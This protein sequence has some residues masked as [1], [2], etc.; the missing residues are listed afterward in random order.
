MPIP[1]EIPRILFRDLQ[2][3]ASAANVDERR[4][5]AVLSTEY[6]VN[7]GDYAEV[8]VHRSNAVDLSRA[9]LPLCEQHDRGEL[10]IG[11]IENIHLDGRTL[12]GEVVLGQSARAAE[13]WPDIERGIVRSLSVGY[14]VLAYQWAGETLQVT[15]WQPVE[16]SLVSVPADPGAG[17]YRS[18][19]M[20]TP[21]PTPNPANQVPAETVRAAE[22]ERIVEIRSI[23]E[24]FS[25]NIPTIS[26]FVDRAIADG[27]TIDRFRARLLD[28]L[29]SNDEAAGGHINRISSLI[30]PLGGGSRDFISAASDAIL[31]RSGARIENPHPATNDFR[32][33]SVL[34]LARSCVS[35][36]G[37]T[38]SGESGEV[39]IR[40]AMSTSD[41]PAIVGDTL[42]KSLR[43]GVESEQASHRN[44]CVVTQADDFRTQSRV[45]LGSAPDLKPVLELGEYENGPLE[46]DRNTLVPVKFGRLVS[47]SWESILADNL[48][49]FVGIGRSL[50]QAAMRTEADAIY[51]ALISNTLA[52]PNLSDG[53]ALF[54]SS[55]NNTV[56]VAT[57]TGK[58]LTATALGAARAK[59][60]RQTNVGGGLLNL[61]P[62]VLIVPPERE[63]EAEILVASSTVHVGA[64][65][66]ESKTPS[67]IGGLVIV[68]EP[69]LTSTDTFY[70]VAGSDMIGTGEIAIVANGPDIEEIEEK[71]RDALTWKVRHAFAAGFVDFRGIVRAT[72]T[73]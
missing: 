18:L 50:G 11:L 52:G 55:R 67:W 42:W 53:E 51:G 47:L 2:L 35:R 15:Q 38:F 56:S 29:A 70:L 40:A 59:L 44:W 24:R 19:S 45:I 46:E 69:R 58:P 60:R 73:T 43:Q 57:G 1:T 23:G 39:I 66:A 72:I 37:R 62:R 32:G 16:V 33:M 68:A 9:P 3:D 34:D 21:A 14:Q 36:S 8:L 48:G 20:P 54:D 25:S 13:L 65:S 63:M 61:V 10:N 64:A 5:P 6:P 17:L 30:T 41:F 26:T 12:R 71:K 27:E 22:R 4:I 31:I 49:A 28:H 7:R